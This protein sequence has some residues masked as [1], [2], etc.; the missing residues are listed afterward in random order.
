M[1]RRQ[2]RHI[3]RRQRQRRQIRKSRRTAEATDLGD[4]GTTLEPLDVAEPIDE[5]L[6]RGLD[7]HGPK[8]RKLLPDGCIESLD[9]SLARVESPEIGGRE[10][11]LQQQVVHE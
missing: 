10:P 5:P 9:D 6:G 3:L 4:A 1:T 11:F 8:V 2:R 7:V